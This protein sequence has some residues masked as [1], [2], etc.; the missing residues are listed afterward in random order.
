MLG[1][2]PGCKTVPDPPRA[3]HIYLQLG[4]LWD[5]ERRGQRECR[6]AFDHTEDGERL[7]HLHGWPVRWG[8]GG[9]IDL[10]MLHALR[11]WFICGL[12]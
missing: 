11:F 6:G 8:S 10:I 4:T 3:I 7:I 5:T 2:L 1:P 12:L 9:G